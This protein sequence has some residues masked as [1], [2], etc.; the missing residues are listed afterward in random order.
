MLIRVKSTEVDIHQSRRYINF[1]QEGSEWNEL[2]L[3]YKKWPGLTVVSFSLSFRS[4]IPK[5]GL[6]SHSSSRP[7]AQTYTSRKRKGKEER[8]RQ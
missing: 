7:L 1:D 5:H 3:Q 6:M 2:K 4:T 8:N